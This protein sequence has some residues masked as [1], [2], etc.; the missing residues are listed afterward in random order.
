M[1]LC[2]VVGPRLVQAAKWGP[3]I[4]RQ[5]AASRGHLGWGRVR[6]SPE[7]YSTDALFQLLSNSELVSGF[8]D[9]K[10]KAAPLGEAS[11]LVPVA[12]GEE[13]ELLDFAQKIARQCSRD[14]FISSDSR[15]N[16]RG[17]PLEGDSD[18]AQS[19]V[20]ARSGASAR[21]NASASTAAGTAS[22]RKPSDRGGAAVPPADGGSA[23]SSA[24]GRPRFVADW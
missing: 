16:A 20:S 2:T 12:P 22:R 5:D 13:K 24:S 23:R 11:G 6:S 3:Q 15:A 21:S 7:T 1:H 17:A 9:Q 18:S 19:T 10:A 4:K 8:T 14:S